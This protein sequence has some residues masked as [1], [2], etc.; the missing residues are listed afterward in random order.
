MGTRPGHD[1]VAVTG[2]AMGARVHLLLVWL[3]LAPISADAEIL[4]ARPDAAAGSGGAED[5]TEDLP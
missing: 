3:L 2:C 1:D 5:A 4:Y